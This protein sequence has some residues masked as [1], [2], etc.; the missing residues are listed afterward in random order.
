MSKAEHWSERRGIRMLGFFYGCGR[1]DRVRLPVRR[2]S[3]HNERLR[4]RW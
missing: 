1:H 3:R 4:F 2:G